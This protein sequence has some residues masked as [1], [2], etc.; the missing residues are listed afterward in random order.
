MYEFELHLRYRYTDKVSFYRQIRPQYILK[1]T[2]LMSQ[3][4]LRGERKTERLEL[5]VE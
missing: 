1:L 3:R 5:K 4:T 2:L